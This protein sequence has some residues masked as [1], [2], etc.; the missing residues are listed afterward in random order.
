MPTLALYHNVRIDGPNY[1]RDARDEL[2]E[3]LDLKQPVVLVGYFNV[4][5][6]EDV[7]K[8][9][10]SIEEAWAAGRDRG[11]TLGLRSSCV[12][13]V[14]HELDRDQWFR[15]AAAGWRRIEPDEIVPLR[16]SMTMPWEVGET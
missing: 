11:V 14:V 15:V 13:D 3:R 9:S 12:G 6:L 5:T 4:E 16:M 10:N 1:G 7:W 8:A 2:R